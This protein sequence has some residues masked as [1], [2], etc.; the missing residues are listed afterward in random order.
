MTPEEQRQKC[1]KLMRELG[2]LRRAYE[3]FT[4]KYH[5]KRSA[6]EIQ[7]LELRDSCAHSSHKTG[8]PNICPDCY[9]DFR[10]YQP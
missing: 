10:G 2:R 7:L 5:E 1:R 9:E 3:K 6:A 4:K 8:I